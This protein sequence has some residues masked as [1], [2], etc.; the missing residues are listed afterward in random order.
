[1]Y[2]FIVSKK[3]FKFFYE[4]AIEAT[5]VKPIIPNFLILTL[6]TM[7]NKNKLIKMFYLF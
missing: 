2:N 6:T 1:M 7:N 5:I 3:Y 4:T